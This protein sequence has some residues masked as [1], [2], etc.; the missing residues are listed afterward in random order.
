MNS[1]SLIRKVRPAVLLVVFFGLLGCILIFDL[2]YTAVQSSDTPTQS[3]ASISDANFTVN[4]SEAI[5]DSEIWA[6]PRM[7]R[8]QFGRGWH[9]AQGVE[10]LEFRDWV[11][12][13]LKNTALYDDPKFIERG[14]R[15]AA[16]RREKF[17][18]LMRDFP[19][20]AF[21]EAT[22]TAVRELMP[23][24]IQMHLEK[25]ESVIGD[26]DVYLCCSS[27]SHNAREEYVV[28][29]S[30]FWK[31]ILYGEREGM[32]TRKEILINGLTL[33]DVFLVHESPI[34]VLE[35]NSYGERRVEFSTLFGQRIAESAAEMDWA[36]SQSLA[37]ESYP[38]DERLEY[39]EFLDLGSAPLN[40]LVSPDPDAGERKVLVVRCNIEDWPETYALFDPDFLRNRIEGSVSSFIHSSS[41]GL[42]TLD[43]EISTK[44]YI[45]G[46]VDQFDEKMNGYRLIEETV[47][48]ELELD[49]DL[50]EYDHIVYITPRMTSSVFPTSTM[51]YG[52]VAEVFGD[53]I[54]MNGSSSFRTFTHE[55][56]HNL[57][58]RH[59][60]IW[61]VSGT[62]PFGEGESLDYGDPFDIMGG[63]YSSTNDV[64]FHFK[65]WIGWAPP[66]SLARVSQS[67]EFRIYQF[68]DVDADLDAILGILI[69]QGG[70]FSYQLSYRGT[71]PEP[72]LSVHWVSNHFNRIQDVNLLDLNTP[73]VGSI[74]AHLPLG[75]SVTLPGADA[76]VTVIGA[77]GV[78]P[79]KFLDIRIEMADTNPKQYYAWG[80]NSDGELDIP[81]VDQEIIQ[82]ALGQDHALALLEDGTVIGWGDD[83]YGRA[84]PPAG[85]TDVVQI[86][87][88]KFHSLALKSDGTLVPW[89]FTGYSLSSRALELAN[90][91]YIECYNF[92]SLAILDDGSVE[93]WGERAKQPLENASPAKD[94]SMGF[95][96]VYE[97][98]SVSV[99]NQLS[100]AAVFRDPNPPV[101]NN[102]V[103]VTGTTGMV[104]LRDDGTLFFWGLR[105]EHDT[106]GTL[107]VPEDE[108]FIRVE[109]AYS[110]IFGVNREHE[111]VVWGA[112]N[113]F[114]LSIPFS[115]DK[116]KSLAVNQW[117]AIAI[118]ADSI[119]SDYDEWS[120]IHGLPL[121]DRS[122]VLDL[123]GDGRSNYIEYLAGGNPTSGDSSDSVKYNTEYGVFEVSV[124]E[125]LDPSKIK[126]KMSK[127]LI[128]WN[129][130]EVDYEIIE[131][132]ILK[133]RIEP[134]GDDPSMFIRISDE[135]E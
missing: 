81:D 61:Q 135:G 112:D 128:E 134:D 32:A 94:V 27:E 113:N 20:R 46:S 59:A 129:P 48:S 52:G 17:L 37:L 45:M 82:F 104:A 87:A 115:L 18:I 93:V 89:G 54:H 33:E 125:Y 51:D 117:H 77:G 2:D 23:E 55:F 105:E 39:E 10:F 74:D 50:D 119:Q 26:L 9:G 80:E 47:K 75:A 110:A 35:P 4:G 90:V 91:K 73:G 13:L 68:D 36:E 124:P 92:N 44:I 64:N 85:L 7:R 40:S 63:G 49:Y 15:L 127:D 95:A 34:M 69:A 96:A 84:T 42:H 99:W 132:G 116:V 88:G 19:E 65:R 126:L 12:Q 60:N 108:R 103:S 14:V 121:A 56:G 78:S 122:R 123:D 8:H 100:Y 5:E 62:D 30:Q 29:D 102:Y 57:G 43:A 38:E 3:A 131:D 86:E 21:S 72:E 53:F 6:D 98:G 11:G 114:L 66:T 109:H 70:E 111:L 71:R 1:Q 83:E 106:Y 67:G 97:D 58:C 25:R 120:Q 28:T 24:E 79:N 31:A 130:A 118:G 101:G 76:T 22:P 16:L 133:L 107:D 41:Y